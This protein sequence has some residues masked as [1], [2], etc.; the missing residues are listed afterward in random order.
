MQSG[1]VVFVLHPVGKH[2]G[3]DSLIHF[4]HGIGGIAVE[5]GA[6]P[7]PVKDPDQRLFQTGVAIFLIRIAGSLQAH[8]HQIGEVLAGQIQ[9]GNEIVIVFCGKTAVQEHIDEMGSFFIAASG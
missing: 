9:S 1:L 8:R 3:I 5:S 6:F 7:N 2:Q 4:F